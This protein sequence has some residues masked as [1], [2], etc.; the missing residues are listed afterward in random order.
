MCLLPKKE[1]VPKLIMNKTP[2]VIMAAGVSSRMRSSSTPNNISQELINQSNHRVKGFIQAGDG[3]E[4]IIFYIIKNSIKAG[5]KDFYIILSNNSDQ[6]Q[7]YL[8]ELEIELSIQIKFGFQDFYGKSKPMGTADA[9]FQLMNQHMELKTKRFIVCNS[10]NLYSTR[11]IKLLLNETNYN[12][13]IAYNY[14]CLKF[15]E[16]RL[17]S[18]SIL[19][20]KENFLEMIIEKPDMDTIKSYSKRYVSM[21]IFSFKGDQ[22]YKYFRDCPINIKRGEKEISTALQNMIGD[23]KNSMVVYPLCEHV[24]DLTFKED[25]DKISQFLN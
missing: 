16:E 11:A 15:P 24:P 4:P 9:L 5:I 18:F 1:K 21:N 19:K 20:I 23:N 10:D 12:S 13:M 22:V 3:N 17:S 7:E 14:N 2:I 8:K 25:I 6:F